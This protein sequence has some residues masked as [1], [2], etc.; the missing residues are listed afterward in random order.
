MKQMKEKLKPNLFFTCAYRFIT[1]IQSWKKGWRQIHKIKQ[2][3]F[4]YGMF[5]S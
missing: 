4:F 3:R 5:Y 2:N 1:N